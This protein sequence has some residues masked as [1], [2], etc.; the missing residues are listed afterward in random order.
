MKLTMSSEGRLYAQASSLAALEPNRSSLL[1]A[2]AAAASLAHPD[3]TELLDIDSGTGDCVLKLLEYF[4]TANCTLIERDRCRLALARQRVGAAAGGLV[5]L[6][7]GSVRSASLPEGQFDVATAG[8]GLQHLRD[9]DELLDTFRRVRLA[10]RENGTFWVVS[11]IDNR[12]TLVQ[13]LLL[14]RSGWCPSNLSSPRLGLEGCTDP[15]V[16]SLNVERQLT[17][18]K[19]AGFPAVEL[20]YKSATMA[21]FVGRK[22]P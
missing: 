19:Q 5:N 11:R 9:G 20:L 12:P 17:L 2:L 4:P 10:L 13:S 14:Q 6:V 7:L 3:A 15:D 1:D 21:T 18:L 22:A 16:M 8:C